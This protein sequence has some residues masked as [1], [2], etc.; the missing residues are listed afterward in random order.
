MFRAHDVMEIWL[1]IEL[2]K[3]TSRKTSI[4]NCQ[5]DQFKKWIKFISILIFDRILLKCACQQS[6]GSVTCFHVVRT[7]NNRHCDWWP[8]NLSYPPFAQIIITWD[9]QLLFFKLPHALFLNVVISSSA[10]TEW[11]SSGN[12]G[13]SDNPSWLVY[14][15]SY[16]LTNLTSYLF[17]N[18]LTVHS[19]IDNL[20]SYARICLQLVDF[21]LTLLTTYLLFIDYWFTCFMSYLHI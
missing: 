10:P 7:L 13:I 9:I 21:L 8:V 5:N 6:V 12:N 14:V 15:F 1:L 2:F 4:S 18:L 16:S 19:I 20:G 3:V 17:M 11:D